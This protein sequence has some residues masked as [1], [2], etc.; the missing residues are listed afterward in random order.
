MKPKKP[1]KKHSI[2]PKRPSDVSAN[3]ANAANDREEPPKRAPM[4]P[5]PPAPPPPP[6]RHELT[7][8][9]PLAPLWDVPVT[10]DGKPGVRIPLAACRG[11]FTIVYRL[12]LSDDGKQL[13]AHCG[14]LPPEAG[15][16]EIR[17]KWGAGRYFIQ[18]RV[19]QRIVYGRTILLDGPEPNGSLPFGPLQETPSGLLALVQSDP[20]TAAIFSLHQVQL[21]QTREDAQRMMN[22]LMGI[23]DK[24]A[25]QYGAMNINTSLRDQLKDASSRIRELEAGRDA[26]SK[27]EHDLE[28]EKLKLK[29][30]A[31]KDSPE[32]VEVVKGLGEALPAIEGL[33]PEGVKK[34]LHSLVGSGPAELPAGAVESPAVKG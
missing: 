9:E 25:S 1:A 6:P 30:K 17:R 24:L 31:Q 22:M 11:G 3:A 33:V 12:I 10:D 34:F 18:L 14:N 16:S 21:A 28:I 2:K 19:G 20:L 7:D 23:L 29:H 4:P 15:E 8:G 13:K 32:W 26:I 5:L 27:R